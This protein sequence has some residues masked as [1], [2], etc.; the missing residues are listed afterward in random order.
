[1]K[2]LFLFLL[3]VSIFVQPKYASASVTATVCNPIAC[4]LVTN[5]Y[6]IAGASAVILHDLIVQSD[7]YKVCD[8]PDQQGSGKHSVDFEVS[9]G[10]VSIISDVTIRNTEGKGAWTRLKD[11][12]IEIANDN[13][14]VTIETD[15]KWRNSSK[16]AKWEGLF[17]IEFFNEKKSFTF[18]ILKEDMR[19]GGKRGDTYQ[20]KRWSSKSKVPEGFWKWIKKTDVQAVLHSKYV[21][22]C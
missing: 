3:I 21:R 7:G 22:K 8:N 6:F 11:L 14:E 20:S 4:T 5:P 12:E 18:P 2:F 15:A 1:M 9:D 13:D 10:G 16:H 17:F 19:T